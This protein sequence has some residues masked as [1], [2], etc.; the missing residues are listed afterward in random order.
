MADPRP[1]ELGDP[2]RILPKSILDTDLYKFT[3]Q[4]A[5]LQ[6]FPDAQCSYQF[7]HRDKHVFFTRRSINQFR[8]AVSRFSEITLTDEELTWLPR[9]CPYFKPAYLSYLRAYRFKPSQV[10]IRFVPRWQYE[11]DSASLPPSPM[12]EEPNGDPNEQGR[13]EIEAVG[14]WV[15]AILWEVPL[16]ATLSEIYFRTV[17][18]DWTHDGQED[19]AYAKAKAMLS[20]GCVFSEFG[21]RRRRSF[22]VQDVVVATLLRAERELRAPGKISGTSNVYLAMKYGIP[23]VGTIAHE[24]FM[25]IAA[26]RGYE[27][28]NSIAMD[29]WEATYKNVL[30]LVLTDTFSTQAF[31]HVR[32]PRPSSQSQSDISEEPQTPIDGV[33]D[34]VQKKVRNLNKKLKAIDELKEKSQRGER[35]EATQLKKIESEVEIRKEL[36]SLSVSS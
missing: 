4:Q 36:T 32:P 13:V 30:L 26:M 5:V 19:I 7:T 3:M 31:W 22:H 11:S 24:W 34:P 10:H 27:H 23:A 29:L 2:S 25:G 18:T 15:E 20:A 8:D 14:P 1:E 33:L 16:M 28:A 9:A 12:P 6:H 21:T 35:L 17:D